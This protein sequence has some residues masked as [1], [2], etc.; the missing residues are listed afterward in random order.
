MTASVRIR[1][2]RADEAGALSALARRAKA[3][4]GYPEA[5]LAEWHAELA[6]TA[7]DI[8]SGHV[9]VAER[10]GELAGVIA[11][12]ARAGGWTIDR[13][14]VDP[15]AQ[16]AGIGRLLVA[17]ARAHA[18]RE[19]RGDID[20]LSDPYAEAFYLRLGAVRDGDVPAPMPGAPD[21][22]LPRL[23]LAV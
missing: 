18:A 17:E 4:W 23:V 12:E 1:K 11:L 2:G 22:R 9:W 7:G 14:W 8:A 10:D 3:S 19:P 6:F 21:R 15:S 13:L 5:W 16:G 20:V